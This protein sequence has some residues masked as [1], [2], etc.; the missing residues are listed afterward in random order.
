MI[1]SVK[2]GSFGFGTKDLFSNLDFSVSS[3]ETAAL[4]GANGIG[5]TTLLRCLVGILKWKTGNTFLDGRAMNEFSQKQWWSNI[6]FVPQ[7]KKSN[8]GITVLE[9]VL[10][11]LGGEIG[12]FKTPDSGDVK[13]AREVLERLS[14]SHIENYRFDKLSGGEMQMALIARAIV[15]NPKI[16][17]LD[18][19]ESNLDFKNQLTVMQTIKNLADGGITCIFNTHYPQHALRY[20]DKSLV[21]FKDG[22]LFGKSSDIINKETIA[23][24]FSVNA[25]ITDINGY[26]DIVPISI[27]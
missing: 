25:D 20:A 13:R 4:L 26:K 1:L 3:G 10:L 23:R 7:T 6:S 9:S 19:P 5:K 14:V 21:L 22:Y 16:L 18:E 8:L 17:I 12:V 24:A 27:I 15:R 2:N 11:G